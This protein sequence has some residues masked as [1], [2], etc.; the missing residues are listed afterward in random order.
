MAGIGKGRAVFRIA[1]LVPFLG[2]GAFLFIGDADGC[3]AA[4]ALE[5]K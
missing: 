3:E 5:A 1:Q 4:Q 2:F